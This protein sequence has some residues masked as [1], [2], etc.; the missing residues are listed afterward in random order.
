MIEHLLHNWINFMRCAVISFAHSHITTHKWKISSSSQRK[1]SKHNQSSLMCVY[2]RHTNRAIAINHVKKNGWEQNKTNTRNGVNEKK[3]SCSLVR[4]IFAVGFASATFYTFFL[5][6]CFHSHPNKCYTC[7]YVET[8]RFI[9]HIGQQNS[10]N[11]RRIN[12]HY[13]VDKLNSNW[14]SI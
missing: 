10:N 14:R 7:P 5:L 13:F 4:F 8:N 9:A 6:V 1:K 2:L 11:C 3:N 12:V